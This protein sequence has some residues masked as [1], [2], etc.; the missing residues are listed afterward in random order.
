MTIIWYMVPQTSTATDRFFLSSRA[1]FGP[2][3]PEELKKFKKCLEI[4]AFYTSVQKIMTICY[5][6][7]Q[8]WCVMDVI[9]IFH[10]GL[11]L[12]FYS[13]N[14]RKNENF[15]NMEKMPGDVVIVHVHH[16]LQWCMVPEIWCKTESWK[17][18]WTDRRTE[19]VT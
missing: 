19:K 1:I 6:V 10:F 9:V 5:T 7:P 18:G 13:P 2:F 17:D 15:K 12:A 4:S 3:T 14:T 16:K 11:F 8:I